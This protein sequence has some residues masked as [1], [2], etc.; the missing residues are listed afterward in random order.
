M[1]TSLPA[2]QRAFGF[3]TDQVVLLV[4][5]D[6]LVRSVTADMVREFGY[7]V[8]EAPS[9]EAAMALLPTTPIDVLVA[10]IGLPG[11][12]GHLFAA[13][14]RSMRPNLG[15]VFVSGAGRLP[16]APRESTGPVLLQKPYGSL[17][18]AK[19]LQEAT[20]RC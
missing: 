3:G 2:E 6:A 10:D 13:Q 8:V 4:E 20:R 5:D 1:N 14:L 17:A 18:L 11:M 12:S 15:I 9:A 7:D 16:D 19:A